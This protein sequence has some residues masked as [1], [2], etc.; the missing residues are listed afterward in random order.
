MELSRQFLKAA[1]VVVFLFSCTAVSARDQAEQPPRPVNQPFFVIDNELND[2]WFDPNTPGQGFFIAVFPDKASIFLGWFTFDTEQPPP[3]VE[4]VLGDP[5]QRWLTAFG[6]WEDNIATL[7]IESTEGGVF[8]NGMPVPTQKV[9]GTIELEFIDCNNAV[10]R[11]NI[12]ASMLTGEIPITRIADDNI[13][14]CLV[15]QPQ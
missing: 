13:L 11:Y 9:S 6:G 1:A 4:A 3:D 2:A 10:V 14:R 7:Q 8:N 12:P 15:A 5:G